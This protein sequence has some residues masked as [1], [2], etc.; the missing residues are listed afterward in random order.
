MSRPRV[1][2]LVRRLGLVSFFTDAAS[3]MV[4]PLLPALLRS[5]GTASIWL[6]AMEGIAE[7]V[8]AGVKWRMGALTDRVERKKPLVVAGYA[9][10][11][12]SR[13]LI[14][15]ASA[16]W[17]VVLLRALDRTGKGIR[18]VPRDALLAEAVDEKSYATAFAFH[19]AMDNA[20]S[21]LG[22]I[23]AFVLLRVLALPVRSVIAL[24]LV[25][26]LVSLGVLA[27]GVREPAADPEPRRDEPPPADAPAREAAA[28]E[29][30]PRSLR[31]YLVV[32]AVFALGSS[33]DSFLLLRASDLGVDEAWVPLLWLAFSAAKALSNIPGG[34]IADRYGRM[35]TLLFAWTLYAAF[36]IALGFVRTPLPFAGLV[37]AYGTYYG[38]SEGAERAVL[39]E[40]APKEVRGRAFAAMHAL[41]GIAVLPANLIFG[42]LYR[43]DPTLAF[44]ASGACGL[45]AA[46]L[47]ATFARSASP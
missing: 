37:V 40:R 21:V 22:P 7:A 35:P 20:G 2:A 36:Y 38:L 3:E 19:R 13:P 10:A 23:L 14:S 12:F 18:G 34:R 39:A 16:G 4:Y 45:A 27:F 43:I 6:G 33:A 29:A 26:G 42:V 46:L 30:L 44:T 17:H 8:S 31:R 1:P 9:L 11:T 28:G 41:T 32:V 25:P 24:A 5:F 47:G 15:L